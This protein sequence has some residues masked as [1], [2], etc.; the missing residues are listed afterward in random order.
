MKLPYN[1]LRNPIDLTHQAGDQNCFQNYH[2]F[3]FPKMTDPEE[4]S[5]EEDSLEEEGSQ[6]DHQEED[7]QEEDHQEPDP[8]EAEDGDPHLFKYR[9]SHHHHRVEN[10]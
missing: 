4:G 8:L 3:A 1:E 10:W 6:E 5:Q 7:I 2:L 9:S